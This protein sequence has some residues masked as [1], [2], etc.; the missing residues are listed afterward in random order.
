MQ[1]R[2][3]FD[4]HILINYFFFPA[5]Y[6]QYPPLV[7]RTV[8]V[9]PELRSETAFFFATVFVAWHETLRYLRFALVPAMLV[10]LRLI[11]DLVG[12]LLQ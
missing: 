7:F 11:G 8:A 3:G 10:R 1:A 4:P 12:I 9:L 6:T 2:H 5:E